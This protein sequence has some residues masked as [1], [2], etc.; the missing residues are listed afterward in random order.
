MLL[1]VPTVFAAE[2]IFS[3][4]LTTNPK[5]N[6][7]WRFYEHGGS[8]RYLSGSQ[9]F[10]L[11][12]D[13]GHSMAMLANYP[14]DSKHWIAEFEFYVQVANSNDGLVFLFYKDEYPSSKIPEK[15]GCNGF[16][17]STVIGCDGF[18][19]GEEDVPG[20]GVEFDAYNE[21]LWDDT[22]YDPITGTSVA[23]S[24]A[25]PQDAV[26]IV[27]DNIKKGYLD[28]AGVPYFWNAWN[29]AT[30]EF[31][32]GNVKVWINGNQVI[33]YDIPAM[34]YTYKN[35]GFS[36]A[37][38]YGD[39]TR[40][41]N[42]QL[43][44]YDP[45]PRCG[46]GENNQPSEECDDGNLVDGDGCS[47][48]CRT[49]RS[50]F[51][52]NGADTWGGDPLLQS[53]TDDAIAA[54]HFEDPAA[55]YGGDY[56]DDAYDGLS[57]LK[58]TTG[59]IDLDDDALIL[60]GVG[61][62]ISL[63]N[64]DDTGPLKSLVGPFSISA[65]FYPERAAGSIFLKRASG[66]GYDLMMQSGKIAFRVDRGGGARVARTDVT[67]DAWHHAVGTYD[68]ENMTLYLDG[69]L[70]DTDRIFDMTPAQSEFLDIHIGNGFGVDPAAFQGQIDELLIY[71][72]VLSLAEIQDYYA[73]FQDSCP[74]VTRAGD[75]DDTDASIHPGAPEVCEDGVDQDC[76]GNDEGCVCGDGVQEGSEQCDDGNTADG[77]GCSA[78]CQIET[79]PT[80]GNGLLEQGEE[81][82]DGNQL[83]GDTCS[84]T[85]TSDIEYCG[86]GITPLPEVIYHPGSSPTNTVFSD[87]EG[88]FDTA[89]FG[90]P[91]PGTL[92]HDTS[93]ISIDD[94]NSID[95]GA[96]GGPSYYRVGFS[97]FIDDIPAETQGLRIR[98]VVE[99]RF[100]GSGTISEFLHVSIYNS[101]NDD[102]DLLVEAPDFISGEKYTM[103]I[104]IPSVED[105]LVLQPDDEYAVELMISSL[106]GGMGSALHLYYVEVAAIECPSCELLSASIT[107]DDLNS[108]GV[109]DEGETI[110]IAGEV[111]TPALC[112]ADLIQV[113]ARG[114]GC[115]LQYAGGDMQGIYGT[116]VFGGNTFTTTW[117]I[118][119]VRSQCKGKQI[120]ADWGRLW[121][122]EPGTGDT[123]SNA[124]EGTGRF[125]FADDDATA[126]CSDGIDNDRDGF[127]D[128]DPAYVA[129]PAGYM[130]G[131]HDLGCNG[132]LDDSESSNH[133]ELG[134]TA[135][136]D[137]IDNDGDGNID[138]PDDP[139]CWGALDESEE[140]PMCYRGTG[141]EQPA[142][143][144]DDGGF[145]KH[146]VL[147][148][149]EATDTFNSPLLSHFDPA[150]SNHD[151]LDHG[152]YV[153]QHGDARAYSFHATD[154][155]PQ[156][157]CQAEC[158]VDDCSSW[159]A[160][161][162]TT[163]AGIL[164][165][166]V[167]DVST[168]KNH[169]AS[170]ISCQD[171][172]WDV[173]LY[174]DPVS[175]IGGF[176]QTFSVAEDG[177][178]V[179][180]G[181]FD[182]DYANNR[183]SQGL[184]IWR[185]PPRCGD[186][187]LEDGEQCDGSLSAQCTDLGYDGGTLTCDPSTCMYD[188]SGCMMAGACSP[189]EKQEC[190]RDPGSLSACDHGMKTCRT[191]GT[192]GPCVYS[193][194]VQEICADGV[195][196]DCD[197][198]VDEEC[199]ETIRMGAVLGDKTIWCNRTAD[200]ICPEFFED[201][202][203]IRPN[204]T[205]RRYIPDPDCS[206]ALV[207][208]RF[209]SPPAESLVDSVTNDQGASTTVVAEHLHQGRYATAVV[210]DGDG[211]VSWTTIQFNQEAGVLDLVLFDSRVISTCTATGDVAPCYAYDRVANQLRVKHDLSR[212]LIIAQFDYRGAGVLLI[213]LILLGILLP[214]V[215]IQYVR[216]HHFK[217]LDLYFKLF[218]HGVHEAHEDYS[219]VKNYVEEALM[220]GH[221]EE[222]I[223]QRLK[224]RGWGDH[225]V[226]MVFHDVHVAHDDTKKLERYVEDAI[227]VGLSKK[228]IYE[229]LL[230][231][232]WKK[233]K[234]DKAF[235]ELEK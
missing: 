196:N 226:H 229:G 162:Y 122:G 141:Y 27:Q 81:C 19:G 176:L 174:P 195:D 219:K 4:D 44:D 22:M 124:I 65:W 87:A 42:F 233:T 109:A 24:C 98:G 12:T 46:D 188:T 158:G 58:G 28:C 10:E 34:D 62:G 20:Y 60:D 61:D 45:L 114:G 197:G 21:N 147:Y 93:I 6:G 181:I 121:V 7:N 198:S 137:G 55:D 177:T 118:P 67:L 192:W 172:P 204:C 128:F 86:A 139:Y 164:P 189:Y 78:T 107:L 155:L 199:G 228:E 37:N 110:G 208:I 163:D 64:L 117:N 190:S 104:A 142:I 119:E 225:V 123:A 99:P 83:D 96:G 212:H 193:S 113:D 169:T 32:H 105:Y 66:R 206:D 227:R 214:L 29:E 184:E 2:Y 68:G 205:G 101:T 11:T 111:N 79:G 76:D 23:R 17:V 136:S 175:G 115:D 131:Y 116:P 235:K 160:G 168:G 54:W 154:A 47:A 71:D 63:D 59:I 146:Y 3:E 220:H 74:G 218:K 211:P 75:C 33:D 134:L 80:C 187:F 127:I 38:T 25:K 85:C 43:H 40:I 171:S 106:A 153:I 230:N 82:D 36:T 200:G 89:D 94:A 221:P 222:K 145:V 191:D 13:V 216:G 125:R 203:G 39:Y 213:L 100:G 138:Y 57:T 84:A 149:D 202:D 41:R 92:S 178:D 5:T 48:Y 129:D 135:C 152:K 210:V 151:V 126:E 166:R 156:A 143:P 130:T 170:A 53:L 144:R 161:L 108:N 157:Q 77:D 49:E 185:C 180:T 51:A 215:A 182:Q 133:D 9:E 224:D 97:T 217:V 223:R 30:I 72:R 73:L 231:A 112:T 102:W 207:G 70:V 14:L 209:D 148:A 140:M 232:G 91:F 90:Y 201:S 88:T 165:Q 15:G 234:V 132:P 183:G 69:V 35:F 18:V 52:D 26:K 179:Y 186:G 103:G 167:F 56:R 50:C 150:T 120:Q 159:G 173:L 194:A 95:D 16:M 31:D 1:L 8:S